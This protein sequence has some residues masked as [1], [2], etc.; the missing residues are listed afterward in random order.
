V[1][2][3][4]EGWGRVNLPAL[5]GANRDYDFTDQTTLLTNQGGFEKRILVGRAEEPLKITLAYT[6][7]PGFPGAAI[8]LVNDL[9][10]EVVAPTGEIFRGNQFAG[11]ESLPNAPQ[12]DYLNNVEAVH[13][14]T[15]VPG[16]YVIRIRAARVVEDARRDTP[17]VD[18]DFALVISA[19]FGAPGAGIVT[20]DREFYRAPDQIRLV[21]VDYDLAGQPGATVQL[22]SAT[23]PAGES[24]PLFASGPTGLF[25]NAISTAAG[26]PLADGKLQLAHA[27]W[28]EAVYADAL[29]ASN[30]VAIAQADLQPPG[31]AGLTAANEFGQLSIRW[32]TDELARGELYYGAGVPNLGATNL[33]YDTSH[34]IIPPGLVPNEVIN[35]YVVAH[36]RAGNRATNNNGSG[37][38]VA[39]NTVPPNVLLVDS[40]A[41]NG[42]VAVP[43]IAGY[44]NALAALGESYQMFD[45]TTSA[46]TL[47]QLQPFP[48][49]IW[50]L[51]EISAP[52][53][54]LVQSISNYVAGGGSL[55]LTSMDA[56]TRLGEA[57]AAG[58]VSN[59]LQVQAHVEDQEVGDIVG[60]GGEPI[61][62]GIALTLDYEENYAELLALLEAIYGI[63]DPSD[64]IT[65]NPGTAAP[66]LD[67]GGQVVGVR[68]P[69]AGVDLPGRVVFLSFPLDTVPV[70]SGVGNNRAGLLRNILNFLAPQTNASAITLNSDVYSV[71]GRAIVE[72]DDVDQGGQ[73]S[74]PVTV[75]SPQHTNV[76]NLTLTETARPGLFRG[77]L[78]LA[79]TNFLAPGIY[80]VDPDDTI[81]VAYF[82][83]SLA[84]TNVAGATI[85]TN[86]P[87]IS[88]V[89]I[90]TA[91]FEA[92]VTWETTKPADSLV[93]Y[94]ESPVNLPNNYV[95]YDSALTTSHQ[96]ILAGLKPET[97]YY[98]RVTSRDRAGNAATDDNGGAFHTFTL[99]TPLPPPWFD[100]HET[101][102]PDW[103]VITSDESEAAWTRGVPGGG[104]TAYSGTNVWG[105]NLEGAGLTQF[106]SY[107]ISPGIFLSG[108]NR[109]TLRFQHQY[110]FTALSEFEFQLAALQ[111]ITNVFT[112][113][114]VLH[115][116]AEDA[117][118]DWE[119]FEIDL[120]PY[121]GQVVYVVWYHF[122]F[123]FDAPPRLGWLV[124]DVTLTVT[125][126]VPGTI[127]ITNNLWQSVFVLSGP[128]GRT[129]SGRS[130]VLANAVPGQ[131]SIQFGDVPYYITP[132]AQNNSLSSGQTI[133]FTGD[134]TA[135]DV[136]TNA[137]P[138]GY[139]AT[140]FGGLEAGRTATTDTD[141]DGL[142]DWA[143]FVS[144]TDPNNPPPPF[145][146]VT[147]GLPGGL[148]RFTWRSVT[149]HSYRVHARTNG[150]AWLPHS[151][152]FP[153]P[154]TNT[155][156]TVGTLT[157]G[158]AR[159][160]RVEAAPP[161]NSLAA[162]FRVTATGLTN[163]QVRLDWPGAPGHGYRVLG[164]TNARDWA[165]ASGWQRVSGYSGTFTVAAPT[166]GAP[167]LFRVEAEP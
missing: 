30:R 89:L 129:A 161:E 123:S 148:L 160:F 154:G 61:G 158:P 14:G 58:F 135:A 86:A 165:A 66:V 109:A 21:L 113:P 125:N 146:L 81:E 132:P 138:D 53:P 82:D 116:F 142:S 12:A 111:L 124:D 79:R 122:L 40:Y 47:A 49:V 18:Q 105:S 145:R 28:I 84:R 24:Y 5:I 76:L 77:D 65:P 110:D 115:Q 70:G 78:L 88:N 149:N 74:V 151:D 52:A 80:P 119:E 37:G 39:T 108:G 62:A 23:E 32:T 20:L 48:C 75:R 68:S 156:Y 36:D 60:V 67:A 29:P 71:P 150:G 130:L 117:S 87:V 96:V 33:L 43:D 93:Q 166:N 162:T 101:N 59:I 90:N 137:L 42:L 139:E 167:F 9:D 35:Y 163:R 95:A 120:T 131:Y 46:P 7:V 159:F 112:P 144:G 134:Y 56:I 73:G 106:E 91:Y 54:A 128:S 97:T 6:D 92:V 143:E 22:R 121:L 41:E 152:W 26:S 69:K 38:F 4:D 98:V 57:G 100:N 147:Q 102:S 83:A 16:E 103:F 25:T 10:L 64:W 104:A 164:S 133:T 55:L 15:P 94:S 3:M 141:G 17:A 27:D 85:D 72:V 127:Q 1:P 118:L 31:I 13:L 155:S 51:D 63:T 8:A 107:L 99:R 34:E 136:N 126:V 153:A 2:N 11:G 50:R 114:I 157:N 19:G 140:M 44:T 45:A